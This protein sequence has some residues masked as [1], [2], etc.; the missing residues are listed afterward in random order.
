MNPMRLL[1]VTPRYWPLVGDTE[2]V[3]TRLANE[4]C[5]R[6]CPT[7]ILTARW[8]SNWPESVVHRHAVVKRLPGSP[9][10]G[11]TTFRYMRALARWVR[12]HRAE[13]DVVYVMNLRQDAYAVVGALGSL[14]PPVVLRSQG[15]RA[16]GDCHWQEHARFGR[17][18]RKR[19]QSAAAIVASTDVSADELLRAGYSS[20]HRIDYGAEALEPR[21]AASRFHAREA[22]AAANQ[23]LEVAEFAPVAICVDRFAEGRALADLVRAWLPIADRW[24]SAK[25]WL[26]GDGPLRDSLYDSIVEFGLRQQIAMPGSFD[27]LSELYH[28]ADLFVSPSPDYGTSQ[29]LVEAMAAGLPIIATDTP[30]LRELIDDAIQGYLVPPGDRQRLSER[31]AQLIDAT[32][33]A[34]QYG[35]AARRRANECFSLSR[36]VEDHITLFKQL[37]YSASRGT[38]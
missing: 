38:A 23:D 19:C 9:R 6:G 36:V 10:G 33:L 20:V 18:I 3:T 16:T 26:I 2:R 12:Q 14:D 15:A 7:T 17:R 4:F 27:E 28:A 31:I 5:V 35:L 29:A 11:W 24:P 22:L 1:M 34:L 30:D 8:H 32:E 13:F 37:I 21:S 25:L